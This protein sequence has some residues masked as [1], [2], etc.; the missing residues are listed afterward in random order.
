M[1]RPRIYIDTSVIGG[2]FDDEFKTY[3]KLLFEEF[4]SGK[5][6][7]VV[8]DIVLF[9][10]EGAPESVKEVLNSVPDNYI[11]YVFLNE[12]SVSLASTY[13]KEGVIA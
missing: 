13:L 5:K 10:L 3:S 8:S 1:L 2:C 7:I 9:E 12:K 11:E 6:N 4:I